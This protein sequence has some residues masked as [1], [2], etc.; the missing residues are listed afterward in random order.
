M[1]A[2]DYH[3]GLVD[4]KFQKVEMTFRHNARKKNRKRKE[5]S[6]DKFK[7]TF[8][9]AIRSIEGLLIKHIHYLHSDEVFK[10]T[11]FQIISFLLFITLTKA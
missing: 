1:I 8:N 5:V 3:P 11:L 7:T 4:K 6:M 10:K 2:R 9:P